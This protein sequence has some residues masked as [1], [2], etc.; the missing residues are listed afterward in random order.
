VVHPSLRLVK[1]VVHPSLEL[2]IAFLSPR[3]RTLLL[4]NQL[5]T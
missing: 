2:L 3:P 4:R 1:P 5:W